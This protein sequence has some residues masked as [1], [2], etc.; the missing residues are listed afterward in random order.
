M[1]PADTTPVDPDRWTAAARLAEGLTDDGTLRRRTRVLVWVGTLVLLSW[2]AGVGLALILPTAGHGDQ[3]GDTSTVRLLV[4][5]ALLAVGFIVGGVGFAWA[6][7][8]GHYITRWRF[9]SS[10]LSRAEKRSVQ[11]Q[12]ADKEPLDAEHADIVTAVAAQSRRATLGMAPIYAAMMLFAASTA[13]STDVLYLRLLEV[14]VS[15]CFIAVFVQLAV[16]YRRAG[17]FL[18]AHQPS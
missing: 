16:M 5:V 14:A 12:I 17:R 13:V 8:T 15:A 11:R 2:A 9:V 7:R 3:T 1:P 18:A 6:Y 10:P 4:Q